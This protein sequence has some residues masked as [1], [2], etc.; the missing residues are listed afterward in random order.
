M[1]GMSATNGKSL[2]G[3]D[4]LKQSIIDILTTPLGS[5]VMRRSYG[6]KL[7]ML[8]DSPTNE[9]GL[10]D[11]VS[12]TA[13]ALN[14]WEPRVSVSKVEVTA[15]TRSSFTIKVTGSYKPDGKPI[16]LEGIEIK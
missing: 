15:A 14:A 13:E 12:A 4:H 2:D 16:T 9:S 10:A 6:S 1:N 5:R 11:I 7:F 8:I 3:K